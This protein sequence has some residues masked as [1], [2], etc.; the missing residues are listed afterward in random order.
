MFGFLRAQPDERTGRAPLSAGRHFLGPRSGFGQIAVD[1]PGLGLCELVSRSV[2]EFV[3]ALRTD[4]L[5]EAS[6]LSLDKRLAVAVRGRVSPENVP[7]VGDEFPADCAGDLVAWLA[8]V[9]HRPSPFAELRV[10]AR[11]E[12]RLTGFGEEEL[13]VL[14]SLAVKRFVKSAASLRI[15][16]LVSAGIDNRREAAVGRELGGLREPAGILDRRLGLRGPGTTDRL[17]SDI[18]R[19]GFVTVDPSARRSRVRL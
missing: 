18:V 11:G 9:D 12:D 10:R 13:H 6:H 5:V 8:P 1:Q 19:G 15:L 17:T 7:A 16:L 2:S 3:H 4:R 14:P